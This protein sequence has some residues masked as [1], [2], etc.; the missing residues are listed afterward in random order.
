VFLD[1]GDEIRQAEFGYVVAAEDVDVH[2]GFEGVGGEL[3]DGGEEVS[4]CAGT[5]VSR[6]AMSECISNGAPTWSPCAIG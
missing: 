6:I 2:D 3:A 1:R 5:I 4:C